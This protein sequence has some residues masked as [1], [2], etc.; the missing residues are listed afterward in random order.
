MQTKKLEVLFDWLGYA[1]FPGSPH[2]DHAQQGPAPGTWQRHHLV[3][4]VVLSQ[5]GGGRPRRKQPHDG[6][7]HS[8]IFWVAFSPENGLKGHLPSTP[9]SFIVMIIF[10]DL[11]MKDFVFTFYKCYYKN[12]LGPNLCPWKGC[13]WLMGWQ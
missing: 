11:F 1:S 4:E 8:P 6:S 12:G 13:T 10:Y 2:P 3:T 9:A 5:E 7:S